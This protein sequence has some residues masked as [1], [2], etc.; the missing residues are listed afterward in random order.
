MIAVA[1]GQDGRRAEYRVRA[2]AVET[3]YED[4]DWKGIAG[5]DVTCFTADELRAIAKV[6]DQAQREK[7]ERR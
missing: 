7:G 3:K 4:G 6:L 2:G 1:K 5:C